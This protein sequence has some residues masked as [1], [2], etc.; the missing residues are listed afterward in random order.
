M[1]ADAETGAF[2]RY[3]RDPYARRQLAA[4]SN[5]INMV[6]PESAGNALWC[7]HGGQQGPAHNHGADDLINS[8]E[9]RAILQRQVGRLFTSYPFPVQASP[10][11]RLRKTT[12]NRVYR[13]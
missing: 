12:A 13:L 4:L 11:D 8:N 9:K 6:Q 2:V 7:A 1:N 10:T 3:W 5:A